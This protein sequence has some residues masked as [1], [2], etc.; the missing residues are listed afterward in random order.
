MLLTDNEIDDILFFWFPNQKYNK[1]W[2]EN[3]IDFDII[4]KNKYEDLMIK[5]FEN[6][7]DFDIIDMTSNELVAIIILLDQFSR[8]IN[9]TNYECN[10][11]KIYSTLIDNNFN[12]LKMTEEARRLSKY[13]IEKEYYLTEPINKTVFA[14]MPLRHLNKLH[15]YKIILNILDK[16][17][18]K[19]DD[20]IYVKFKN[21]TVRRKELL[22]D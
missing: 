11:N 8:N 9:R 7:K 18:D 19:K 10:Q 17:Q 1:F 12:I 20:E 4:I 14:L 15:D 6:I 21:Q 22:M 3:N 13:W 16:I 2:F 5:V